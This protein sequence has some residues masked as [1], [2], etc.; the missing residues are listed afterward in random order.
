MWEY[1]LVGFIVAA[2]AFEMW[3]ELKSISISAKALEQNVSDGKQWAI[4][5][6]CEECVNETS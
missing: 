4:L 2:G 6:D 1:F 5:I 3:L